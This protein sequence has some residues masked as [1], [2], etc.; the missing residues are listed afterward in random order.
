MM[1]PGGM[2]LLAELRPQDCAG[3]TDKVAMYFEPH[4]VALLAATDTDP[5]TRIQSGEP[6]C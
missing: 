3:L 4:N 2:A 5:S 1:D 6:P